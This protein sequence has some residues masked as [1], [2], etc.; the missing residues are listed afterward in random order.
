[1]ERPEVSDDYV[2]LLKRYIALAP[3]LVPASAKEAPKTP[4]H[5]DLHLDNIFVDPNTK[6]ITHIIDWQ[7]TSACEPFL[8]SG[9]PQ[10]LAPLNAAVSAGTDDADTE[11]Q[12]TEKEKRQKEVDALAYYRSLLRVRSPQRWAALNEKHLL[13]RTKPVSIVSGCW[14]REDLFSF[15]HALIDVIA[16]WD[17]LVP[18]GTS[19]PAGFTDEELELHRSKMEII[20]GLSTAMHQLQDEN[21]IPLGDMVRREDYEQAQQL[22][23]QFKKMFVELAE[24]DRQRELHSKVWP[25]QEIPTFE[26]SYDARCSTWPR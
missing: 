2:S 18:G 16:H 13:V 26:H 24:D 9:F 5:P 20:Q 11:G 3:Y 17:E 6:K 22:N 21:I 12:Q 15:R 1:M 7:S 23:R 25:Y 4:S 10:M 19:C 14:P 8:Q